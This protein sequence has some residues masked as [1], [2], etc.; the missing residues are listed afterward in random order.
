V[1]V[2]VVGVETRSGDKFLLCSDGLSNLIEADEIRDALL[3]GDVA[4]V[5]DLLIQLANSRGGDDNITVI[6]V[7]RTE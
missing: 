3:A 6:A 4:Q 1:L 5:P 2:D 7:H